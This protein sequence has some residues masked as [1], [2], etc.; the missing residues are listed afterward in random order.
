MLATQGLE[1]GYGKEVLLAPLNVSVE[2][3]RFCCLIG[4]NGVGKS[5]LIRTLCGMQAPIAGS[6]T[7]DG[8]DLRSMAPADR[9]KKLAVVL[10]DRIASGALSGWELVALGRYPHTDWTGRLSEN[11]HMAIHDA[12]VDT[13]AT[14]LQGKLL[15]E[16]SDGERQRMMIARAI[17]QQPQVLILDEATAFLDLPRRVEFM[18]L[19]L[20]LSRKRGIAILLSTHDLELALRHADEIWLADRSQH[21]HVGGPE[22]L[23]LDGRFAQAFAVDGLSFDPERGELRRSPSSGTPVRIIGDGVAAIWTH[24]ALSR[25]GHT[26]SSTAAITVDVTQG[27]YRL[28]KP[29]SEMRHYPTLSALVS[30]L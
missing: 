5:T 8:A 18:E 16:M 21:L 10:T 3:D 27:D 20:Q 25:V 11:D 26:P 19:L 14:D 12:L 23:V 6:I 9:A 29:G 22:D 24:R 4:A 7:L 30:D 28:I 15:V 13:G 2:S 1:I 17:A